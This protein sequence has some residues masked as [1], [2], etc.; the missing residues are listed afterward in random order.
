MYMDD[1][2]H[3]A[4]VERTTAAW[5]RRLEEVKV[6]RRRLARADQER[7]DQANEWI[8]EHQTQYMK[9]PHE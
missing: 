7:A 1:P 2:A 9:E 8:A 4:H 3:L 6:W 5:V